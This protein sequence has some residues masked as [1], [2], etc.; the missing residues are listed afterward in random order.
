MSTRGTR[1]V[2]LGASMAG[3]LAARVLSERF[4]SVTVVERDEL[5]ETGETRRGVPQARHAHILLPRGVQ[6]LD[7][8][9]PGLLDSL[10]DEG[11]PVV[12][13]PREFRFDLGGHLFRMEGDP[14]EPTYQLS[15]GLLEG[16]VL[17]RVRTCRGVELR[18]GYDVLGLVAAGSRV[19]GAKVRRRAEGAEDET[20]DADLVVVAT[21]RSGRTATWLQ[22]LGYPTPSEEELRI[23]LMYA[24]CRLRA[25]LDA[26]GDVKCVLTGPTPERPTAMA[27]FAEERGIWVLTA[28][29][30]TGVHPPTEWEPYLD[31][32]RAFTPEHVMTMI[33]SAER[34]TDLQTHQ[35]PSNLRRRYDRLDRFPRGLLVIGDALCSFNPIYGQGMTVA[36]LEAL[37]LRSCLETSGPDDLA[38]RFFKAAFRPSNVAWQL[39]TG[40]DLTIPLVE[41]PRPIPV[42]VMN[43][44]VGH[45]QSAAARDPAVASTFM[46]VTSL[47]DPPGRLLAPRTV[48]RVL[49][50]R[51]SRSSPGSADARG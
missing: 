4:D 28:A 49:R 39:A 7:A 11:V 3:L 44:Y 23:G 30:Y 20:L 6:A 19:S 13:E 12:L 50:A 34:L 38:P 43:A 36:A 5:P 2:V 25:P 15:R 45:V 37:A 33:E 16:R 35:F 14:I 10:A 17:E 42:R 9:F 22:S 32:L 26:L 29:G 8:L 27:V 46:R 18:E 48:W 31:F 41:A 51:R 40:A 1:A 24:S 21:G 47:L